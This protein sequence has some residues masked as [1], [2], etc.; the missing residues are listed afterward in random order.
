VGGADPF[1]GSV[2]GYPLV[3]TGPDTVNWYVERLPDA[4]PNQAALLPAPGFQV[5]AT[6]PDQGTRALAMIGGTRLFALIGTGLY[7]FDFHATPTLRGRVP[8]D[9]QPGQ[10]VYN[11]VLPN[12]LGIVSGGN[13]YA[14]DLTANTLGGPVLTGGYTHLGYATSRGLALNPTTG[15]V[16]LSALNDLTTWDAGTFFQRSL[17]ADPWLV[18]FVDQNNLVWLLG[19]DSFETW[20]NTGQGTQ[21]FAP[22]SGL[23]GAV[24]VVGPWAWT[25]AQAGNLWMA[26][27]AHGHGL[28]MQTTGGPPGPFSSR[29]MSAAAAIYNHIGG[30]G[31]DDVGLLTHQYDHHVFTAVT[32]PR[33]PA[34]WVYDHLEQSWARRGVWDAATG[35]YGAWAPCAH[36]LAFGNHLVGDRTSGSL[37]HMH[38]T[39]GTEMDGTAIRR[40]RRAPALLTER[41]RAPIDQLE[42]LMDVGVAGQAAAPAARLRVSDDRG[43]TWSN[44]LRASTGAAGAWATRVYWTRLGLVQDAVIE[45]TYTDVQPARVLDAYVNNLEAA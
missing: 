31:L 10:L 18:L 40:L 16:N 20:Y 2:D 39:F 7:E 3:G 13:I 27:N 22:L 8:S 33:V 30:H 37:W 1:I 19:T 43:R 17:F 35:Q 38:G 45:L 29:A 15:K 6:V 12:Q 9:G 44:E 28:L 14:Y 21:P 11:G 42:L 36:V 5:W 26:R 25:M 32:F 41:K 24:G 4:A 34:T 23:N